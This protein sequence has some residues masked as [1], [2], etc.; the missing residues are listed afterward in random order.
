M[1]YLRMENNLQYAFTETPKPSVEWHEMSGENRLEKIKE[2]LSKHD[3]KGG[4]LIIP[5]TANKDG[6]IIIRFT[7][8]VSAS[9]RGTILLDF[10]EIL[11]T[12]I[13]DSLTVWLEP[14]GDK[15][16]LRNLR[17]IQVKK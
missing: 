10:E 14:L 7:E 8:P 16:S 9:E 6:Q 13:D 3:F 2:T 5:I 17:G 15:N 1:A 11:K 4:L 12:D